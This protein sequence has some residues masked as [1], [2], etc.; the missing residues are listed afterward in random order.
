MKKVLV[1][2][3]S[4]VW[5]S[6]LRNLLETN[7]YSV[8]FAKDG[9]D[10]INKFFIF[11]PDVVIV[12]YIMPK[13]N[14]VHFT[15]FLRSFSAFRN[16]GI[17]MLTGADETINPFWA[18]RSGANAFL[19]KT[20]PQDEIESTILNFVA[21]PYS[22]EWTREV[23]KIHMEPFGELVD[24][25]DESL[26]QT[27]LVGE[28]VDLS[29]YVFDEF[30]LLKRLHEL[31]SEV[32]E[33]EAVY[34]AL[35]DYERVKLYGFGGPTLAAPLKVFEAFSKFLSSVTYKAIAERYSGDR[36]LRGSY[37]VAE[38]YFADEIIGLVMLEGPKHFESAERTLL[39]VSEPLG[40]LF[41]LLN[42]Y[43]NLMSGRETEEVSGLLTSTHFRSKVTNA[44]D[45]AKRNGMPLSLVLVR[46]SNLGSLVSK[47]GQTSVNEFLREFGK[48][49]DSHS[50]GMAGR[51][52]FNDFCVVLIGANKE[53]AKA[54]FSAIVDGAQHKVKSI[55]NSGEQASF[56]V[57]I[58]EWA[59]E[60]PGELIVRLM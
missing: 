42:D 10:G 55:L 4:E 36:E 25:L 58:F 20:A 32:L 21:K 47:Y 17:L 2:D 60:T 7:G 43:Q 31:L 40:K 30:L 13:L 48:L 6:F 57:E 19:K 9:L 28:I 22:I 24:I 52:K 39:S 37:M 49:L 50:P 51:L 53:K 11:L 33:Y 35:T 16:V 1:V 14:G 41:Y 54:T 46:L 5:R 44:V 29:N 34:F 59:G 18:K 3:D 38:V 27:T 45:F 12:D 56:E 23:Y 8:E 26:R 15:R